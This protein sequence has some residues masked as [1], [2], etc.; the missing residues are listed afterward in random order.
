MLN[1]LNSFQKKPFRDTWVLLLLLMVL[2][3]G[4]RAVHVES[5]SLWQDELYTLASATGNGI[6]EDTVLPGADND[7]PTPQPPA[8]YK[9][10]VTTVRP[11]SAFW[12]A[13]GHNIQMPLYPLLMRAWA[14]SIDANPL[15]MRWFSVWVGILAIPAAFLLGW[16]VKNKA[17]GLL[18]AALVTFSGFQITYSQ[19]ARVYALVTLLVLLSTWLMLRLV[20]EKGQQ[21]GTWIFFAFITLLGLYSQYLYQFVLAFQALYVLIYSGREKAFLLKIGVTALFVGLCY[22]PWLPMMDTQVAF[23]H[24]TGHGTLTGLWNPLS[25]IERLWQILTDLISPKSLPVKLLASLLM[26]GAVAWAIVKKQDKP[27]LVLTGLWLLCTVGG[28][29]GIDLM[30]HTHRILSKRY[31]ILASPALYLLLA[32]ALWQLPQRFKLG[33]SSLLLVLMAWN[34]WDVVAGSKFLAKEN[35]QSAGQLITQHPPVRKAVETDLVLVSHSGVHAAA[36]AFYL[37][38]ETAMLGISRKSPAHPWQPKALAET[39]ATATQQHP[40]VWLVLTHAPG[41]IK[42]SLLAWFDGKYKNT[43]HEKF[44]GVEVYLFQR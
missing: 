21:L 23:L 19:T 14:S 37:P 11:E 30:N 8:F 22:W 39:L 40:R 27:L 3:A 13:L 5:K 43:L 33:L 16:E 32:M 18:L 25:L 10:K 42:R 12:E 28:L 4:I 29:I 20:R 31:T 9:S 38:A 24:Q 2:G 36:M 44:S 26:G 34:A 1:P 17:F 35:Y 6:F 7:P 41:S 15:S